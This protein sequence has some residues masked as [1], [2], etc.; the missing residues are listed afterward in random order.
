MAFGELASIVTQ[1]FHFIS[2]HFNFSQYFFVGVRKRVHKI[3]GSPWAFVQLKISIDA[4]HVG[5]Q[6]LG[7]HLWTEGGCA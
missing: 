7:A 5:Q 2:F 1:A 3:G 4:I 6:S